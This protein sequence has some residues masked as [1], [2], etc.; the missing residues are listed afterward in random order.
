MELSR[1]ELQIIE[2]LGRGL[3]KPK[4][5]A[6]AMKKSPQQAYVSLDNLENNGFV[7]RS[8]GYVRLSQ[9]T[10]VSMLAKLLIAYPDLKDIL[11]DSGITIL[12]ALINPLSVNELTNVTGLKKSVVYKK[13]RQGINLSIL[14]KEDG[15]Y[16]LNDRIWAELKETIIEL[17]NYEKTI[18]IRVPVD[19]VIYHKTGSE[20]IFSTV[21]E[22]D[23]SMT[24]FSSYK[25]YGLSVFFPV[26]YY[27]LP[28]KSLS[29]RDIFIHSLYVAEKDMD[30]RELTYIALF[31]LKHR[32]ALKRIKHDVLDMLK[33]VLLGEKISAY[34]DLKDITEKAQQYK[35]K[36]V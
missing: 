20:I 12:S 3:S 7:T 36:V 30:Y 5:L 23:A 29:L 9:K 15:S 21:R 22:Q 11:S 18:D 32:K 17:S 26:N 24:A 16:Y 10:H 2:Q 19:A 1:T 6:S 28:A 33:K 8:R 31:Y 4:E 14:R 13:V 35:I 34:P 27:Y 25:D